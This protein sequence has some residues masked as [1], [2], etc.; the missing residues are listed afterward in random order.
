[1][2][3]KSIVNPV[4]EG[5]DMISCI[6]DGHGKADVV[7]EVARIVYYKSVLNADKGEGG[8]KRQKFC[9]YHEWMLPDGKGERGLPKMQ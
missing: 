3:L 5:L 1:M 6:G 8:Q 2:L 9:R 7:R 4:R